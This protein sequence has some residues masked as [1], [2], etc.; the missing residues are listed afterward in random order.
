MHQQ[1]GYVLSYDI[2]FKEY[3]TQKRAEDMEGARG[4][5]E[6]KRE[7][8]RTGKGDANDGGAGGSRS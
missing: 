2:P 5:A 6:R 4:D 3:A 1:A 8:M 7:K